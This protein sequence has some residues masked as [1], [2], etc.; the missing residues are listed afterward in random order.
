MFIPSDESLQ[1]STSDFLE[2]TAKSNGYQPKG[3]ISVHGP[4]V[5][6]GRATSVDTSLESDT[7]LNPKVYISPQSCTCSAINTYTRAGVGPPLLLAPTDPQGQGSDDSGAHSGCTVGTTPVAS[8]K[9]TTI[10]QKHDLGIPQVPHSDIQTLPLE[11]KSAAVPC[12]A[13]IQRT[14]KARVHN[15]RETTPCD[16]VCSVDSGEIVRVVESGVRNMDTPYMQAPLAGTGKLAEDLVRVELEGKSSL[17]VGS[18]DRWSQESDHDAE[19]P[20]PN[21]EKLNVEDSHEEERD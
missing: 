10:E 2:C 6:R 13:C 4:I 5:T 7:L 1:R 9:P 17:D 16:S 21:M 11:D 14:V 15:T 19:V 8:I 20:S 18:Q 12:T 3:S